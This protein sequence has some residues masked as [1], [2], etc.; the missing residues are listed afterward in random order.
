MDCG[1][2]CPTLCANKKGCTK[3]ADCKSGVCSSGKC[4]EPSCTDGVKNGDETDIDCGG[5]S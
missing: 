5:A 2:S 4:V 3:A 1:G